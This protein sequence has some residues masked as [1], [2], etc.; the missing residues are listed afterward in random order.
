MWNFCVYPHI[1]AVADG[2][3]GLTE[4]DIG[5]DPQIADGYAIAASAELRLFVCPLLVGRRV[6]C[7]CVSAELLSK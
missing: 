2:A 6:R 5:L 3:V 7:R 4:C 1:P